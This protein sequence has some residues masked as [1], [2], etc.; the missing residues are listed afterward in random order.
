LAGPDHFAK[1]SMQM[2][3]IFRA[4][5]LRTI[6]HKAEKYP[7]WQAIAE[8][9]KTVIPSERDKFSIPLLRKRNL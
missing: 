8:Y 2:S 3:Q 4:G 7:T 6:R 9:F 5:H 1:I